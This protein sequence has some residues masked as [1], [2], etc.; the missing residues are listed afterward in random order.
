MSW[1]GKD[2]AKNICAFTPT[3]LAEL[4]AN[5]QDYRHRLSAAGE[6]DAALQAYVA[7]TALGRIEDATHPFLVG[8]CLVSLRDRLMALQE[9][10]GKA[11]TGG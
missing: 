11:P 9:Q 6:R 5:L 7:A 2:A 1:P 4:I 10:S 8:G 3:R